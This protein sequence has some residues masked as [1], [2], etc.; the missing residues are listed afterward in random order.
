MTLRD[1]CA[2]MEKYAECP[3]C[4][5]A[6]VGSGQGTLECDTEQGYFK[7]TCQCGWSVEVK[8]GEDDVR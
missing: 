3:R 8:D 5:C 4:G 7:R 1:A 2:L 6:V